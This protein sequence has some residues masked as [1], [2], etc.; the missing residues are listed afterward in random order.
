VTIIITLR[1]GGE[2]PPAEAP[3]GS[4]KDVIGEAH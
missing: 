4:G 3:A 2:Q 1:Q